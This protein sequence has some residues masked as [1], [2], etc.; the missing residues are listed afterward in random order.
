MSAVGHRSSS[1]SSTCRFYFAARGKECSALAIDG[2]FCG[3]HSRNRAH[4]RPREE[5]KKEATIKQENSNKIVDCVIC[6]DEIS[7]SDAVNLQCG[8]VYHR[9]CIETWI[10]QGS[11]N[12]CPACRSVVK[13]LG[14]P[15]KPEPSKQVKPLC[16]FCFAQLPTNP[17]SD[18]CCEEMYLYTHFG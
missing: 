8:D 12:L 9:K 18:P 1:K 2:T 6:L 7:I 3:H 10:S 14:D 11:N 5:E 4:K 13:I 17:W 15:E 16:H